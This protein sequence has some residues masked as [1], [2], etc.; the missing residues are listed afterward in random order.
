MVGRAGHK[1]IGILGLSFKQ[2]T[3]DLRESP[4]VILA[5]RLLGRGFTLSIFDSNVRLSRLTGANLSYVNEHLPHIAAL[6]R[7]DLDE[8]V[9]ASDTL[10][11]SH[12]ALPARIGQD[13]LAG[14]TIIDLVRY[15]PDLRSGP[16]YDGIC[17]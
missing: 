17:W 16:G 11:V 4:M 12:A 6:L 5:E 13:A 7:E 10:V 14:K 3:D 15:A 8:V 9:A 2:N 1:N